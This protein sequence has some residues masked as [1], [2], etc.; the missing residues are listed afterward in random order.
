[1]LGTFLISGIVVIAVVGIV[2]WRKYHQVEIEAALQQQ[3][4]DLKQ[5]MVDSGMSADQIEKVLKAQ[6]TKPSQLSL[7]EHLPLRQA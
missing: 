2:T 5:K 4:I 6:P 7:A 1:M 3:I